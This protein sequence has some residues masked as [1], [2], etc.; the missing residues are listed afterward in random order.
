MCS[1]DVKDTLANLASEDTRLMA[2]RGNEDNYSKVVEM[3]K[4]FGDP[5]K[6]SRR[7]SLGICGYVLPRRADI[8]GLRRN[9]CLNPSMVPFHY[10]SASIGVMAHGDP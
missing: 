8:R 9:V 3:T 2:A 10:S 5:V 6:S 4:T 7:R 1:Q